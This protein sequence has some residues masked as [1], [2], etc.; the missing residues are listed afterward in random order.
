M[1]PIK[2]ARWFV[3]TV[4]A[5]LVPLVFGL[6]KLFFQGKP[7]SLQ[8]ISSRGE[9]LLISTGIAG[10]AIG[11]LIASGTS[12]Q[13]VPKIVCAGLCFI[14]LSLSGMWFADIS[15]SVESANL[16]R[17]AYGSLLVFFMTLFASGGC[18]AL[19]EV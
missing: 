11:E 3:F 18:V 8:A 2:M 4:I 6:G 7:L 16:A 1:K 5:A 13:P 17:L 10:T 12:K 19:S 14:N 15:T 9:L